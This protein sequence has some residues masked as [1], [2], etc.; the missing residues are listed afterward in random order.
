MKKAFL[1]I[2]NYIF[3]NKPLLITVA[4]AIGAFIG[5]V[6][7]S[8]HL[9]LGDLFLNLLA[10]FIASILTIL[11]I[12]H[13]LKREHE[14]NTLPLKLSL[15]RD[16]QLLSSRI[17]RLWE[18]MYV[19]SIEHRSGIAV[20]ELFSENTMKE[21]Y[22]C[23]DLE[24][25]PNIT[26]AQDWFLYIDNHLSEIQKCGEKIL[27]RYINVASPELLQ[28]IHHLISDSAIAGMGLEIM[29]RVRALDIRDSF[30]RL[31]MLRAYALFPNERD[32]AEIDNLIKWCN[33]NFDELSGKSSTVYQVT[34]KVTII[35]PHVPPSSIISR[36]KIEK[37]AMDYEKRVKSSPQID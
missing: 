30:P 5:W 32:F 11:I 12:D 10:G 28:S 21:I 3:C 17:I 24:G 1:S 35:N 19:Q 4:F 8:E 33:E 23:L 26:P 16:V 6:K 22:D 36:E 14:K 34:Q 2:K 31:P 25:K 29:N 20:E 15:Y 37:Y 13:I 27:D 9:N 18:E 7:C